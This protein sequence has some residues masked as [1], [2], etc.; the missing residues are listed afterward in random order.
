MPAAVPRLLLGTFDVISG[1]AS[2]C[3]DSPVDIGR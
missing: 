1:F 3:L 2:S